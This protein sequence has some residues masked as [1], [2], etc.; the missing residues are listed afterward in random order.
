LLNRIHSAVLTTCHRILG[1]L[2]TAA[3]VFLAVALSPMTDEAAAKAPPL[4]TTLFEADVL[5]APAM[6]AAVIAVAPAG[7]EIELTGEAAPGYL[8]VYYGGEPAW[9]PVQYLALGVRPGVDTA[10]AVTD[11]PL[12][13]APMRDART[14]AT[15][16]EGDAV[17]L[18]GASLDG[19]DAASHEGVGGWIDEQDLTR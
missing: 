5:A 10:V 7:T 8:G 3:L 19:Y 14:L 18:T 4:A 9:V 15:V 11:T 1:A 2:A 17:I 13:D 12:L 6:D 16:P